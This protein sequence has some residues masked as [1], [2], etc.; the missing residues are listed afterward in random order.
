MRT[1]LTLLALA[2][3]APASAAVL[4][5]VTPAGMGA[6]V[7]AVIFAGAALRF[8]LD[9]RAL[10]DSQDTL[11]VRLAESER[12][13]SELQVKRGELERTVAQKQAAFE[14]VEAQR[15]Q[16][17]E[18][19]AALRQQVERVARIDGQTGVANHQHFIETLGEEIKRAVRHKKPVTVLLAELDFFQDYV[20]VNGKERGD[21]AL[22]TIAATVSDTFRRAG[23]LVA[24]V[25]NARFAV[26]LPEADAQT[27]Q[28]FAE[29]LRRNVYDLCV[30][31]P[32]SEA[33]DRLTVSV[34]LTTLPPIRLHDRN[35]AV[36]QAKAAL[37][38]AQ[39]NGHNQ[40]ARAAD[41][42]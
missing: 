21:Y 6:G 10:E 3:A 1:A 20:D 32:S 36:A 27:G 5:T 15:A 7:L 23:D 42:A 18:V 26:V 4:H 37:E 39:S 8:W 40:V 2:S 16:T 24:R 33:A 25:G 9:R 14:Q 19:L 41:A 38:S 22:Q 13:V 12:L 29:R 34:G 28:R 31:F 35:D 30:P 11:T 17:H